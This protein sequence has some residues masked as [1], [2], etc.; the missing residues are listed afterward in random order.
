MAN[1]RTVCQDEEDY[2]ND[3]SELKRLKEKEKAQEAAE[4][5]KAKAAAKKA[6]KVGSPDDDDEY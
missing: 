5:E 1:N 4:K 3:Q 6:E 2:N